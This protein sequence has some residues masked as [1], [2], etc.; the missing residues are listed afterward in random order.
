MM[1]DVTPGDLG[2]NKGF[3]K[4]Q[5]RDKFGKFVKMGGFVDFDIQL[6]GVQG[7]SRAAGRF[8]G[9]SEPGVARIEVMDNSRIPKGVYLVKHDQIS[10]QPK[11]V[12][13]LP[14]KNVAKKPAA[15]ELK[16]S[17]TGS[18][19]LKTRLKSVAKD[20]KEKGRF[21]LPRQGALNEAG[22]NTDIANGARIDYQKVFDA[23]PKLQEKY[24]TFDNMW[25]YVSQNGTD[26]TTQSPNDLRDIPEDMK[27]LNRSY[28]KNVL[29][30]EPDGTITVYRNAING[31]DTESESAVG[32]VSLDS[33]MAYDYGSTRENIGANGRYEID[34]KPDE[35][36]GML[37]YSRVED[38]YGLTIGRGV[39]EQ[40]GRVRRVGDLESA[41]LAPWLEDYNNK[42]RRERG[43]SPLRGYGTAGQYDLH[44]VEDFGSDLP[45]FLAKHDLQS[46]DIS[47][48]Y[49][50][51]YGEGAYAN[52]KE[53]GNSLNFAQIKKMF[54]KLDNGN[55]GLN[56]EYLDSFQT[57]K[58]NEDY[59]N[60]QFDN[61]MKMLS[62][63][64]ELT[65]D[66]FMT[67]K[68][69]D[70]TPPEDKDTSSSQTGVFKEY[71]PDNTSNA[72]EDTPLTDLGFD[73]EEEI[74]IYRGVPDDA[75]DGINSG[76]WVSTLPQLAKDY[77]GGGKV[78]SM[79]VK[80]KDLFADPSSGEGAYTEEMV[81]RPKA[82]LLDIQTDSL[83]GLDLSKLERQI[84]DD[85]IAPG[86]ENWVSVLPEVLDLA[87][88]SEEDD[89]NFDPQLGNK[90]LSIVMEM[91]GYNAKPKL[92]SAEEFDSIEGEPLYRGITAE[93]AVDQYKNSPKHFAGQG[94]F[95]NGTYSSDDKATALSYGGGNESNVLEMKLSPDANVQKFDSRKEY[96]DWVD[97]TIAKFR[98]DYLNS[99]PSNDEY[100]DF[101]RQ[102]DNI[103]DYTN[104]AVML[105]IDA[106]E[107]PHGVAD[108][109]R[110]TII[111]NRGKVIVNDKS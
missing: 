87:R 103:V 100:Y 77:A 19:V 53:S 97:D 15:P 101:I 69:R 16:K 24:G 68:T 59:K 74:T 7:P 75:E 89:N 83:K 72:A 18:E 107:F 104:I 20:L 50:K 63:F 2:A 92:V 58:K 71:S 85:T 44:E 98:E 94:K 27:E 21:P 38:E 46:S 60:D 95:G 13:T 67:H 79:K 90:R 22:G 33:Q 57:L 1:V 96:M 30:L 17:V 62:V 10:S 76:D 48:T 47:T 4:V 43:E 106:I 42:F 31:K 73:P 34:V 66:Y 9:N 105:G 25:D 11:S 99:E 86:F 109:E 37:G 8:L 61:R 81:Y 102:M 78:V 35:V 91:A 32:Y 56:V 14:P 65:G 39:T 45:E 5:L 111:L 55:L 23:E 12:A 80:A 54:I 40:E 84:F 82:S 36:F 6:S 88:D 70:Y 26:L 51:L 110:Y 29:G 108:A 28:A 52:Y 93:G 49:D 41:K 3:W 64:Q